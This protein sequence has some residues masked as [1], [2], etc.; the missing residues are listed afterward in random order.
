MRPFSVYMAKSTLKEVTR[1]RVKKHH[2]GA[3]EGFAQDARGGNRKHSSV[4]W[5]EGYYQRIKSLAKS[6]KKTFNAML[7]ELIDLGLK[8]L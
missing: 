8:A 6:Q 4:R 5:R 1:T 2:G 7:H 3:P